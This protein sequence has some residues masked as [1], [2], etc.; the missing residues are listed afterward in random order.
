MDLVAQPVLDRFVE[1]AAAATA[2]AAEPGPEF[3][4]AEFSAVLDHVLQHPAQR[5]RFAELFV[6]V[7]YDRDRD[8]IDLVDY[9]MHALRWEEVRSAFRNRLAAEQDERARHVLRGLLQAFDDGWEPAALY[10]RFVGRA[11]DRA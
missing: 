2:A 3:P 8:G 6:A 9:C 7:A 10:R 11:S 5:A 4:E 1:L